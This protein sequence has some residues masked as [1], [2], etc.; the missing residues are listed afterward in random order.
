MCFDP[1]KTSTKFLLWTVT[2]RLLIVLDLTVS[3]DRPKDRNIKDSRANRFIKR[4]IYSEQS[5]EKKESHLWC[6]KERYL[7]N[8]TLVLGEQQFIFY[9]LRSRLLWRFDVFIV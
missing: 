7:T 4:Q 8:L 9:D 3:A 1:L 6:E 5:K 2:V